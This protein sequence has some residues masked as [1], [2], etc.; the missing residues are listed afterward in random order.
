[1]QDLYTK[2]Y[3]TLLR[4][5]NED[6]NKQRNN[7][8]LWIGRLNIV[9]MEIFPKL[10]CIINTIPIKIPARFFFLIEIDTLILKII[11]KCKIIIYYYNQNNFAVEEQS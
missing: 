7:L 8:Y 11:W 3:K 6:S 10:I 1:M 5:I 9:K 4:G 2:N